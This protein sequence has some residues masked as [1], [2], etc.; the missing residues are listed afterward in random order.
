MIWNPDGSTAEL[1]GNGTRI[2]ARWLARRES[3]ESV[4]VAV[5]GLTVNARM[6]EGLEDEQAMG[7]AL[8]EPEETIEIEGEPVV[9]TPVS[10]GN[11]HA[12]VLRD[13]ER[14]TIL[15][16]GPLVER[17]ASLPAAYERPVRAGGRQARAD[18]RRL[19]TRRGGDALLGN[20][21]LR[22]GG[23][24]DRE[25]LVREPGAR[26]ASRAATSASRSTN[27]GECS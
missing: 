16:L 14:A 18:G 13:P 21:R 3:V 1:S 10:L 24:R 26:P 8:V 22:G 11:P 9:F 4:A 19:G 23:G 7:V 27:P 17:H 15:A 2:A 5:D 12:V 25:R 6:G 20:E